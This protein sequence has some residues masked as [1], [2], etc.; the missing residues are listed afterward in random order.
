MSS[1]FTIFFTIFNISYTNY[2]RQFVKI[3]QAFDSV[4]IVHRHINI[5][6]FLQQKSKEKPLLCGDNPFVFY[7]IIDTR[8]HCQNSA[9][10][11]QNIAYNFE[12]QNASASNT[13][14]KH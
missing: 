4:K 13:Q 5:T 14:I 8:K 7:K 2:L 10:A 1:N 6:I 3:R 9:Y 12:Y 11:Q